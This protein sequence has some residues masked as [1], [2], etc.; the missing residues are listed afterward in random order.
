MT[1]LATVA[2]LLAALALSLIITDATLTF[3]EWVTP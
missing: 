3:F 2:I 1:R